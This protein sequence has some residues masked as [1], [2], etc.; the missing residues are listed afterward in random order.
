MGFQRVRS[1]HQLGP[2]P[3]CRDVP[4]SSAHEHHQ[5][6][7]RRQRINPRRGPGSTP[8]WQLGPRA[9]EDSCSPPSWRTLH[10]TRRCS[11]LCRLIRSG[12]RPSTAAEAKPS[13]TTP[14]NTSASRR[15]P[16]SV[17]RRS[18]TASG[19]H[20]VQW[21]PSLCYRPKTPELSHECVSISMDDCTVALSE[22]RMRFHPS[23]QR[24]RGTETRRR[25]RQI[26]GEHGG[27]ETAS[28]SDWWTRCNKGCARPWP[29]EASLRL[30]RRLA[31]ALVR[32]GTTKFKAP[33]LLHTDK[34]IEG[35]VSDI[36]PVFEGSCQSEQHQVDLV[37]FE[38]SLG[39]SRGPHR[40]EV[41]SRR[42]AA[43]LCSSSL[44]TGSQHAVDAEEC[45]DSW[46]NAVA[47]ATRIGFIADAVSGGGIEC[48]AHSQEALR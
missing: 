11:I 21:P 1:H 41:H 34:A 40:A 12:Y 44:R 35:N 28:G 22:E 4:P 16:F 10:T 13:K 45:Q 26:T 18:A 43:A 6:Q 36:F 39:A 3:Q 8:L 31:D 24:H 38:G 20:C 25:G 2:L 23:C 17:L 37:V 29:W 9:S 47:M 5:H 7:S 42:V 27:I 19:V 14:R 46:K 33:A 30:Y 48:D 15:G 32:E